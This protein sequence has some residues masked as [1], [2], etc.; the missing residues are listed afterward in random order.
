MVYMLVDMVGDMMGDMVMAIVG[1]MMEYM[2]GD[3]V[4]AMVG[5][6]MEYMVVDM[7]GDMVMDT[8]E[9]GIRFL[10]SSGLNRNLVVSIRENKKFV[11][12]IIFKNNFIFL[13]SHLL[14]ILILLI[15]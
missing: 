4:M 8:R 13:F 11:F 10:E 15:E 12:V 6:I 2:V 3:M 14:I 7:I 1:D 9:W 5:D